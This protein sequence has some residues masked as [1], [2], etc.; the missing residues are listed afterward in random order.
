MSLANLLD[1][2]DVFCRCIYG[3]ASLPSTLLFRCHLSDSQRYSADEHLKDT[4]NHVATFNEHFALMSLPIFCIIFCRSCN[5]ACC[6]FAHLKCLTCHQA[7]KG[8]RINSSKC[9]KFLKA[10]QSRCRFPFHQSG[11][12][13]VRWAGQAPWSACLNIV[14]QVLSSP[15]QAAQGCCLG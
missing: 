7:E 9:S 14:I 11:A 4:I 3:C 2:G 1:H 6:L 5:R 15:P 12:D 8:A 13:W 10:S